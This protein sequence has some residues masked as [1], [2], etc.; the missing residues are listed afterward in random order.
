MGIML[1]DKFAPVA[2]LVDAVDSKSISRKGVG[3]RLSPGAPSKLR[4]FLYDF[5]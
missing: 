4:N 3:V 5:L 1:E 2:E